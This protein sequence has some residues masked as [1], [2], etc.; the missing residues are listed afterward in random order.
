MDTLFNGRYED[1]R[2]YENLEDVIKYFQE[3]LHIIEE[4]EIPTEQQLIEIEKTLQE[5]SDQYWHNYP[6]K[7]SSEIKIRL[8]AFI[9]KYFYYAEDTFIFTIFT[10]K[11]DGCYPWVK[12]LIRY[13]VWK[14]NLEKLHFQRQFDAVIS[15]K[16]YPWNNS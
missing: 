9:N 4:I 7:I 3:V 13:K 8:E 11:L 5:L 10:L 2:N 1:L 14:S 15:E 16:D 6:K 12:D